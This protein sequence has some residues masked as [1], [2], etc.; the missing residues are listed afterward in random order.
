MYYISE[1]RHTERRDVYERGTKRNL[2]RFLYK[3]TTN[4]RKLKLLEK[5]D[6]LVEGKPMGLEVIN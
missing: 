2:V 6:S 5:K 4:T 3:M 1:Q